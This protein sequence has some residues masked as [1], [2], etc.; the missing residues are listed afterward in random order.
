[1]TQLPH[2]GSQGISRQLW[3]LGI[4]V[5]I[6]IGR[7]QVVMV[8]ISEY[9]GQIWQDCSSKLEETYVYMVVTVLYLWCSMT[10]LVC[11]ALIISRYLDTCIDQNVPQGSATTWGFHHIKLLSPDGGI[12]C[13][14]EKYTILPCT[15]TER[16]TNYFSKTQNC[17][18]HGDLRKHPLFLSFMC[19][20]SWAKFPLPKTWSMA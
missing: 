17:F 15:S 8:S 13:A 9:S 16:I 18:S 19:S 11:T 6:L 14:C 7:L 10:K 1:M 12:P 20:Y 3:L 5:S 4:I 2:L